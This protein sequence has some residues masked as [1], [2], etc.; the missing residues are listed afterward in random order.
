MLRRVGGDKAL[1]DHPFER[2][3]RLCSARIRIGRNIRRRK[4]G[5]SRNFGIRLSREQ[6]E[7]RGIS[8]RA[9][10]DRHNFRNRARYA[11]YRDGIF[12]LLRI[13]VR[14]R[15][16]ALHVKIIFA[17]PVA[18]GTLNIAVR[19]R[20]LDLGGTPVFRHRNDGRSHRERQKHGGGEPARR[21]FGDM[22]LL[23]SL[24]RLLTETHG[25]NKS[26]HR[27]DEQVHEQDGERHA[28]GIRAE[29]ANDHRERAY[30]ERIKHAVIFPF[31]RG[32]I[33]RRH[34]ESAEHQ[35]ARKEL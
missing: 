28:F 12:E 8:H 5:K 17:V 6:C 29:P 20:K 21:P 22:R 4:V 31:G 26:V 25:K 19:C 7:V 24:F 9:L 23:L 11:V 15:R 27:G 16:A 1:F 34:K 18:R 14:D 30:A 13:F 10:R 32:C 35:P 2:G 3:I 33:I